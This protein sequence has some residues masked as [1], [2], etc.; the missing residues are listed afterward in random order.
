MDWER[1]LRWMRALA[2]EMD[3]RVRIQKGDYRLISS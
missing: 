1:I 3:E 2:A